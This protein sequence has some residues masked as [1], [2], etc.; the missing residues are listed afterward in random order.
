V[1]LSTA[2]QGFYITNT[3][4]DNVTIAGTNLEPISLRFAATIARN[5]RIIEP[6]VA[7]GA[8][9]SAPAANFGLVVTFY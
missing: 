7:I 8:T 1:T 9:H 5:C 4:L 2:F 6:F 3:Q